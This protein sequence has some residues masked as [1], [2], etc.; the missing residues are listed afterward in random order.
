MVN[1][2]DLYKIAQSDWTNAV[3]AAEMAGGDADRIATHAEFAELAWQ[4]ACHAAFSGQINNALTQLDKAG[5]HTA[6][7][8]GEEGLKAVRAAR[9]CL[10]SR[11]PLAL[12]P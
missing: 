4:N 9:L 1:L 6:I 12:F 3:D 11:G 5:Y 10:L 8:L 7:F 2:L